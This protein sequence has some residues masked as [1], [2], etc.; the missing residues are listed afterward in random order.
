MVTMSDAVKAAATRREKRG[1]VARIVEAAP[2]VAAPAPEAEPERE[3]GF[4]ESMACPEWSR[5]RERQQ[6]A[7]YPP[8]VPLEPH[9]PPVPQP[10]NWRGDMY[11]LWDGRPK[12]V[13][14]APK[15]VPPVVPA[16]SAMPTREQMDQ[17]IEP[18]GEIRTKPRGRF[19]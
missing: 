4:Y 19:P 8:P 12:L 11:G 16:Q 14:A 18:T 9:G 17:F 3:I 10:P 7:K 15:S 13:V 2:A 6:A 5:I 1:K